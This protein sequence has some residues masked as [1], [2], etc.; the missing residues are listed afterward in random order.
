MHR[1][2]YLQVL[3][4]GVGLA[5][6]PLRAQ[7]SES[8]TLEEARSALA[9]GRRLVDVREAEE[10]ASGVAPGAQ[11]LPMSQLAQRL[12]ELGT[13]KD[14]PLLL[15]CRTQNRS[16]ATAKR[17]RE[18]GYTRVQFVEGGMQGWQ[19]RGWPTRQPAE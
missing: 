14:E 3:A 19:A 13:A 7:A 8:V 17:L 12:P 1:R 10:H 16:R 18:L 4:V 5:T 2:T 11:L 15:I 9:A 6:P